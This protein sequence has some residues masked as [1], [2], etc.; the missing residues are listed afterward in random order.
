MMMTPSLRRE[1]RYPFFNNIV[2]VLYA[3]HRD[4]QA[5]V[6]ETYEVLQRSADILEASAKRALE[7]YPDRR[8]DLTTWINGAKNMVTGNMAWS[9]SIKRY[10]LRDELFDRLASLLV[11]F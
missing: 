7:R 8:A 2:A 1:L 4:L 10:A 5:S 6:D 11:D 9:M 3:K